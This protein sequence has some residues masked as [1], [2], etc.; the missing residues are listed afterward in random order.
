M[1]N[2]YKLLGN[3]IVGGVTVVESDNDN[4]TRLW[5]MRLDHLS[6]RGMTELYKNLLKDVKSYKLKFCEFCVLGKQSKIIFM[7]GQHTTGKILNYVYSDIWG[8]IREL[9]LDRS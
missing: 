1:G 4:C 7:T 2:I 5:H 6:E 9:S 8:P 3:T